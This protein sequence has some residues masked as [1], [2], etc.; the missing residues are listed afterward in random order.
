MELHN[1]YNPSTKQTKDGSWWRIKGQPEQQN[2]TLPK[3]KSISTT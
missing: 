1:A 3:N 2:K